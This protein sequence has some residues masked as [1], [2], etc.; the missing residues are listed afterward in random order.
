[1]KTMGERI[2][3]TTRLFSAED[4]ARE[5][6]VTVFDDGLVGVI[7]ENEGGVMYI[8]LSA[9]NARAVAARLVDA[10]EAIEVH[11]GAAFAKTMVH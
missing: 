3:N 11:G 5:I 1:M 6:G 8:A 10:S 7:L 2:K 9:P 4:A